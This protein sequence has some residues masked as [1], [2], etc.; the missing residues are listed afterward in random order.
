MQIVTSGGTQNLHWVGFSMSSVIVFCTSGGIFLH[1]VC[2][3]TS[4]VFFYILCKQQLHQVLHSA[5]NNIDKQQRSTTLTNDNNNH[6][7]STYHTHFHLVMLR[8]S[9]TRKQKAIEVTPSAASIAS[10]RELFTFSPF[11]LCCRQCN[12][13]ATIQLDKRS[14][15]IHLK[16]HGLDSRVATVHSL[17]VTFQTQLDNVK[18]LGTI[19]PYCSDNKAYI[20]YSCICGHVIQFRKDSAL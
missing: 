6:I 5:V 8:S 18:A 9:I 12:K 11:G 17:F 7:S 2:L 15:Q 20:G 3:F 13:G 16:K 4:G 10:L 1:Q 14:I 19:E